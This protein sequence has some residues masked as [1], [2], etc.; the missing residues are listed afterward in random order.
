MPFFIVRDSSNEL[1]RVGM[2][3]STGFETYD[4]AEAEARLH[5]PSE[6]WRIMEG[7]T[8]WDAMKRAFDIG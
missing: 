1:S 7:D 4:A 2:A 8:A 3:G 5:Y 6:S